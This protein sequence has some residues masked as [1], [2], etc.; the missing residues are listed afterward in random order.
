MKLENGKLIHEEYTS[1]FTY[2]DRLFI[3]D[4]C[5]DF[6]LATESQIIIK[7]R[8]NTEAEAIEAVKKKWDEVEHKYKGF[9]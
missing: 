5:S 7:E 4:D 2:K 6:W 3:V 1:S 9:K 8:G